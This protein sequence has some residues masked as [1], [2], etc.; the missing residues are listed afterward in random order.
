MAASDPMRYAGRLFAWIAVFC[1]VL[2]GAA[3]ARTADRVNVRYADHPTF[4]RIVFDWPEI[5]PYTPVF[6]GDRLEITFGKSSIPD[7]GS[8]AQNPLAHMANP[9]HRIEGDNLVVTLQVT[10]PGRLKHFRD[11][12]KIAFDI[13]GDEPASSAPETQDAIAP[14]AETPDR[15]V[16]SAAP[17]EP[18][19]ASTQQTRQTADDPNSL[20]L[21]VSRRG[22]DIRLTYPWRENVLAAAFIRDNYLWVVFEGGK[23]VD[24]SDLDPFIGQRILTARQLDHPSMTVLLYQVTPGQNVRAQRIDSEWHIDLKDSPSVPTRP[25]ATGHQRAD[26]GHGENFFFAVENS[27]AVLTLEDPVIGDELVIVP[28]AESSQGVLRQQKFSQFEAL[29]TAQGIAVQMISDNLTVLKYRNGV[30]VS[31]RDGLAITHSQLSRKLGMATFT[32]E[33]VAEEEDAGFVKLIDFSAWGQGPLSGEDFHANK[34][35]LLYQLANSTTGRRNEIRWRLARFYLAHGQ[36]TDAYGVLNVMRDDD[37]DLLESPEFRMVLGVTN[38]LMRRFEEGARLLNH[39]TLISEQESFLWRAVAHSEL[40]DDKTAFELYE[41]GADILALQDTHDQIR[42]LFAATRSAYALHKTDFVETSLTLL[43]QL[44]LNAAQLTEAE[45]WRALLERDG[46]N[47]LKAEERLQGIVKAGVRQT[48]ARAKF[49]LINMEYQN[50]EIDAMEA[51]DRLE[52]LRFAWRG[53]DFELELLS[54]LGEIYV[55]QKEFNIGLQTLKLAVT[56]FEGSPKTA[57]LTRQMNRIYSDLFLNGGADALEP[58]KAVALYSEFRELIPLGADGDKMTRRLAD[59]LVSIDLLEEAADLLNYQI[60]FRLKG[61]AQ[62]VVASRL[63]MIYLLDSKPEDALGIL[64]AT[65]DSQTP[66]D[67]EDRRRMIEARTLIELGRFEE[68]EI[69]LE[70]YATEEAEKLRSDIY[71]KSENWDKYVSHSNRMLDNRYRDEAD[72]SAEERLAVLRLSVAYVI[73]DDKAG[74]KILR[75]RYKAHM[76][77]GLYG[78]TFEVITAERQLT[79]Q[80][81]R[82]LTRSIASVA[83][84]ETFMESYKQEFADSSAENGAARNNAVQN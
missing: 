49:D 50:D 27:G 14:S 11:G 62:S 31:A 9:A 1:L 19:D 77:N 83:K 13:I 75:D 21:Q 18:D 28:V 35:E 63:A 32:G 25:I 78:D 38:I 67:I 29:A 40:G 68:A 39:K 54:R 65:R 34:H 79:D 64:R 72:L 22:N 43:Q 20:H 80:N 69:L 59:R 15:E 58:V 71:W 70:P 2:S 4:S 66:Q 42:F 81:V 44:P 8:L 48:A 26:N 5:V 73:N 51:I 47:P 53:D 46:G 33:A 37:P 45:Y 57:A 56:F 17:P 24:Q 60:K 84:L 16:I 10:K 82:R 30:S 74:V 55:S 52:K 7:W 23:T 12:A 6:S 76:D 3:F 36:K 61:V 41:K